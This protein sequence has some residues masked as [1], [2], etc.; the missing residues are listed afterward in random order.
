M[1]DLHSKVTKVETIP[2]GKVKTELASK[3]Q[4]SSFKEGITYLFQII[5]GVLFLVWI[6]KFEIYL[7]ERHYYKVTE[8]KELFERMKRQNSKNQNN[9]YF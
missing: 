7:L 2:S 4:E 9:K 3:I 8:E 6:L 5:G 1:K